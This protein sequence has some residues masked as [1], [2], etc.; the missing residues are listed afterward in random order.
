MLEDTT[1]EEVLRIIKEFENGKASDI[2]ITVIKTSSHVIA[3]IVSRYL[4]KLMSN[5][6][7]PD[8]LKTGRITPVFKKGNPEEIENYRPIS[9]LS[10]FGKI[11]EKIIYLTRHIYMVRNLGIFEKNPHIF[12]LAKL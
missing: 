9:T 7:F 6:I 2:P 11:F 4:N 10:I 5:G 12:V 8:I 1:P 3:P